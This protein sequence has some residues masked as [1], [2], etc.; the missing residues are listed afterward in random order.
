MKILKETINYVIYVDVYKNIYMYEKI[1]NTIHKYE[2]NKLNKLIKNLE[3]NRVDIYFDEITLSDYKNKELDTLVLNVTEDCNF[4]CGYCI[5]SGIYKNERTHKNIYMDIYDSKKAIDDFFLNAKENSNILFYGGEPLL[6]FNVIRET[7]EFIKTKY[8]KRNVKFGMTTNFSLA[9]K[10]FDFFIKNDFILSISIDG[11]KKIH[12]KWRKDI[13]GNGTYDKIIDG[14]E[15]LREKNNDYFNNRIIFSITIADLS[16][17]TRIYDFFVNNNFKNIPMTVQTIEKRM[18]SV[19]KFNYDLNKGKKQYE[20][21]TELYIENI[22]KNRKNPSFLKALFDSITFQILQKSNNI[23]ETSLNAYGMCVPGFRKLFL[24]TSGKYYMC[25]KI[26]DRLPLGTVSTG[27]KIKNSLSY[28]NKYIKIKN[29]L[30]KKCWAIRICDSC[31][32]AAKSLN[33]INLTSHKK[34]CKIIKEKI[35]NGLGIYSALM[36][37]DYNKNY[38]NYFQDYNNIGDSI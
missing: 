33:S 22:I 32:V 37:K 36:L 38:L 17:L 29:S 1:Y 27:F 6:N 15:S 34:S 26:G 12:D 25:E 19:D 10:Y 9:N 18:L 16:K 13:N 23:I 5:F 24:S 2:K 35:I 31:A 8:S 7:V 30:C 28:Y 14:I 4:R 3:K 20:K 11:N 21:L